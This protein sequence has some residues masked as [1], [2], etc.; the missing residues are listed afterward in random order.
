M[1]KNLIVLFATLTSCAFTGKK[2][3]ASTL[4]LCIR[5]RIDSLKKQPVQNP[6]ATIYQYR[7]GGKTVYAFNAP[8]CDEYNVVVDAD[9]RYLCAPSGGFSGRGDGAC[10]DFKTAATEETLIWKDERGK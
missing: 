8:C 4:P 2:N 6:P 5:Q 10:P 1:K 9:C 3:A 7:Y